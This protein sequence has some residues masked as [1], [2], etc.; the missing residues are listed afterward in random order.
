M[1]HID[2]NEEKA[3]KDDAINTARRR[4]ALNRQQMH[5]S[6]E[7]LNVLHKDEGF[8]GRAYKN[9]DDKITVGSGLTEGVK[10]GNTITPSESDRR[11]NKYMADNT[12]PE[13]KRRINVPVSQG[14]VNALSNG[15]Y[16]TGKIPDDIVKHVNNGTLTRSTYVNGMINH[17]LD[18]ITHKP[19][20]EKYLEGWINKSFRDAELIE[21]K[22]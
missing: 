14:V 8:R 18:V 10:L 7:G 1:F 16:T 22:K 21:E 12:I 9:E 6:Q 13:I 11:S 5:Y 4:L 19:K 17:Y 20:K 15:A 2:Q 3:I